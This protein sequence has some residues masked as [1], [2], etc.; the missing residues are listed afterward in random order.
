MIFGK[1][2]DDAVLAKLATAPEPYRGIAERLH[3][4]IRETAPGLEP[5]VRWACRSTSRTARTSATSS[6]TRTTWP[7]ASAKS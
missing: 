5:V 1:K 6:R 3:A 7:S 2:G 4:I